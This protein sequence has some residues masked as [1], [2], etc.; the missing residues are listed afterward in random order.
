MQPPAHSAIKSSATE[1]Q[2]TRS[3]ASCGYSQVGEDGKHA[4][5]RV[6]VALR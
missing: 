1:G 4:A 3:S 6:G 5:V 2:A